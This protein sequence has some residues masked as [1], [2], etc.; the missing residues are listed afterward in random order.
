[1]PGLKLSGLIV[2]QACWNLLKIATCSIKT[3]APFK[4]PVFDAVVSEQSACTFSSKHQSTSVWYTALACSRPVPLVNAGTPSSCSRSFTEAIIG[5]LSSKPF[6]VKFRRSFRSTRSL[7]FFMRER[8]IDDRFT[9]SS[10]TLLPKASAVAMKRCTA[11]RSLILH[12]SN[13]IASFSETKSSYPLVGLKYLLVGPG[14]FVCT[15]ASLSTS[16]SSSE[17]LDDRSSTTK[18]LLEASNSLQARS[19][20]LFVACFRSSMDFT[21]L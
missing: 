17:L 19:F 1:M 5:S 11:F 2:P 7:R 20:L 4:R 3:Q 12:L 18:N 13:T 14:I 6:P 9:I 10:L 16:T 21:F 8:R 15:N